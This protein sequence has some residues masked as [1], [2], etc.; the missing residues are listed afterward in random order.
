MA[1][2]RSRPATLRA[3]TCSTRIGAATPSTS[4][5]RARRG[6]SGFRQR[7]TGRR[8]GGRGM[9]G[10]CGRARC[11]GAKGDS[12]G[13]RARLG[14]QASCLHLPPGRLRSQARMRRH[15]VAWLASPMSRGLEPRVC[16]PSRLRALRYGGL[17]AGREWHSPLAN[18]LRLPPAA[19]AAGRRRYSLAGRECH[20]PCLP[21]LQAV[22]AMRFRAACR[23]SLLLRCG[24]WRS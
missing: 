4:C 22:P 2:A 3:S 13:A 5:Q 12:A 16:R 11:G 23:A 18:E 9:S 20:L 24:L 1:R 14:A 15:L 10:G 19:S 8:G 6:N 17:A 21:A 7:G